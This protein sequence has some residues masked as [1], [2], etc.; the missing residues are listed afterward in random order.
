MKFKKSFILVIMLLIF[1]IFISACGNSNNLSE[2]DQKKEYKFLTVGTAGVGGA[3]YPIGISIAEIITNNLDI[4]TTAQVTGGAVENNISVD[5][6]ELEL[7]ITQGPPA[8]AAF[9]GMAPYKDKHTNISALFGGLSKG[10]FQVIVRNDNSIVDFKDLKNKKVVLG[11]S[12][13]G[14]ITVTNEVLEFYDMTIDD[15]EPNYISY[16]EGIEAFNDKN[17]DAVVIQSAVPSA[18]VLQLSATSDN[19]KILSLDKE[20]IE[21]IEEKYPYYKHILLEKEIYGTESD[22]D[23]IYLSNMVIVNNNLSEE[24]VYNILENIVV[25][26]DKVKKSHGSTADLSIENMIDSPIPF[27]PG[28]LKF[29]KE[30]GMM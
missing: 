13:G 6:G 26:I 25:N 17:V 5:N 16:T 1:A 20:I 15:I 23:T 27:H 24:L 4:Q 9:N 22:S 8:Y 2:S 29:F 19:Y 10:V 18:A 7:A 3:Y 28:A 30:K 11:P 14:A 21:R 12:G